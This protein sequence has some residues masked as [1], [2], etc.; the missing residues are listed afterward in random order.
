MCK[1]ELNFSYNN[2]ADSILSKQ[3]LSIITQELKSR[4]VTTPIVEQC[5]YNSSLREPYRITVK[6]EKE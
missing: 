3:R 6:C 4:G 1:V 5:V 2:K